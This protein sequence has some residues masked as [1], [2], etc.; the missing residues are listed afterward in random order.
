MAE[1][2]RISLDLGRWIQFRHS[3][4]KRSGRIVNCYD[5]DQLIDHGSLRR[6]ETGKLLTSEYKVDLASDTRYAIPVIFDL[7]QNDAIWC[8]LALRSYPA[9]NNVENNLKGA[10]LMLRAMVALNTPNLYELFCLHA[11]ARGERV[12]ARA[13]ADVVFSVED[14]SV[15]AFDMERISAEF[16]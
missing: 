7:K 10:S 16:L 6:I 5:L 11:E 15:S 2:N 4:V 1:K 12:D 13:Q 14:G 8:D 9:F 3:Q